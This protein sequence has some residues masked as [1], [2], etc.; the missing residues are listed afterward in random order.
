MKVLLAGNG[1]REHIIAR[2]LEEDSEVYALISKK[3]P[4]I[5]RI[6]RNYWVVD[7]KDR[8]AIKEI[9][10]SNSFDLGFVSPDALLELGLS[11][12][13]ADAGVPV[14]SPL[15]EAARIEWD[16]LFTRRLLAKYNIPANP[17]NVSISSM[18]EAKEKAEE[19]GEY[20]VKPVGLTGG[21][22]VKVKGDHFSE[23]NEVS[24]YMQTLIEKDG[25]FLME[26]KLIGEEFTLQAFSDG[27]TLVFM[28]PVQDHKRA[29]ENDEGPNTGGTGSYSTGKLLPF[30]TQKDLDDAKSI[31]R[32]TIDALN[33]EG[34]VFKGVLY[35]QFIA[36]KDGVKLIEY[37]ARFGDP[38]V[39]NVLSLLET[40]L[41]SV[42]LSM[43]K[44]TL[45]AQNV[46]FSD[47]FTVV[48]YLVPEGYPE[49][50]V[51]NREVSIDVD[52]VKSTGADFYYASV[53]ESEGKIYTTRSRAFAVVGKAVSLEEAERVAEK[54]CSF[55]DGP[56]WH[57]RDIGTKELVERRVRHM[58]ELRGKHAE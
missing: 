20:V 57:R 26:E 41:S 6:A 39:M 45:E 19:L 16:K 47:D 52:G 14:A 49:S 1:A 58:K 4:G 55:F 36:T 38:E 21:K 37:N 24:D 29:Y 51:E 2:K 31:M 44:G 32:S 27:K 5:S 48:K 56:V 35:G 22:G 28:P 42:F 25:M 23:F 7:F 40:S 8:E 12:V 34:I 30:L 13:I 17:K 50:P 3:H 43:A 54:A 53:Y 11:D 10:N 33:K 46:K 15:R 9:L 18:E